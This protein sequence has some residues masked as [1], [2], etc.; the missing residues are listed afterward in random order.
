MIALEVVGGWLRVKHAVQPEIH[1]HKIEA[2]SSYLTGSTHR[3]HGYDQRV[4]SV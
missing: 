3:L 4:N 2:Y 1:L